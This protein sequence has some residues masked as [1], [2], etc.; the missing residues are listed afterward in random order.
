MRAEVKTVAELLDGSKYEEA[1]AVTFDDPAVLKTIPGQALIRV[2]T[3]G[4]F[5]HER[6]EGD[7]PEID[8]VPFTA[9]RRLNI[10]V[11]KVS[12]ISIAGEGS[13]APVAAQAEQRKK[14]F[15]VFK[16][17]KA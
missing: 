7:E 5:L 12:T 15:E 13:I 6:L 14:Q 8:L 17:G 3:N 16:G 10:K 2:L 1:N 4:G 11:T 9:V